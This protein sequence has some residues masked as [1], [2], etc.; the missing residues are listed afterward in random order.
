MSSAASTPPPEG[1]PTDHFGTAL[2][3]SDVVRRHDDASALGTL[4]AFTTDGTDRAIVA[5]THTGSAGTART[6]DLVKSTWLPADS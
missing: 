3:T 1:Q 5:W 6:C 2:Q 4:V